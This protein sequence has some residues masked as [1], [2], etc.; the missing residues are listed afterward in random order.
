MPDHFHLLLTPGGEISLERA[1]QFVK[2]GSA[3]RIRERL[4]FR[5]PIWQRGFSDHRVRDAADYESHARYVAANPVKM[6][7]AF[8]VAEYP[9]SSAS[10]KFL[11]DEVPQGLKPLST[12]VANRH[13]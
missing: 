7:L 8:E 10:G 9:W 12:G 2:G 13:G 6:N 5:F 11:M 4:L 3:K 1:V